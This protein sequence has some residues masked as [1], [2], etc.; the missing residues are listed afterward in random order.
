MNIFGL[1]RG[2]TGRWFDNPP[3]WESSYTGFLKLV[4]RHKAGGLV[5][6]H[7]LTNPDDRP[8][9]VF[10]HDSIQRS[11]TQGDF[12]TTL[13]TVKKITPDEDAMLE[14]VPGKHPREHFVVLTDEA[15]NVVMQDY[16]DAER[17]DRVMTIIE[18]S[19]WGAS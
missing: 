11:R 6:S 12:V 8:D 9:H 17:A 14:R 15:G 13:W 18:Q 1:I 2:L 3:P 5:I 4:S 7:Y 10:R 19:G 16:C